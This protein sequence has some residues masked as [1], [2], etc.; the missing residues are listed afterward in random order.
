MSRT[1]PLF[2]DNVSKESLSL[3]NNGQQFQKSL[4]IEHFHL[5]SN[6]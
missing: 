2:L 5:T 6:H 4:Q 3:N 1:F